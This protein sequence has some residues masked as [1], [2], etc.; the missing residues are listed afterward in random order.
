[1]APAIYF[2][3]STLH[4]GALAQKT[5]PNLIYFARTRKKDLTII[6]FARTMA[7]G[8]LLLFHFVFALAP[9]RQKIGKVKD[10]LSFFQILFH[11]KQS[12]MRMVLI[13]VEPQAGR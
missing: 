10:Y 13:W 6:A 5:C 12:Q 1:M 4:F 9:P 11:V 7:R 2:H 8:T 3:F